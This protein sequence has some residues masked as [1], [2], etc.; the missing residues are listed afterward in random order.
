MCVMDR[1][2][3]TIVRVQARRGRGASTRI[4]GLLTAAMS[5]LAAGAIWCLFAIWSGHALLWLALPTAGV[6]V[7]ALRAHGFGGTLAGAAAATIAVV[8][9]VAYALYLQAAAE[10]AVMLGLPLRATL[11]RIGPGL[12]KTIAW[13]DLD[14]AGVGVIVIAIVAAGLGVAVSGRRR[15]RSP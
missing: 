13:A 6:I 14:A 9:A 2:E 1:P 5:A 12:A 3:P 4:I 10:V 7:W 15:P 11:F 8:L